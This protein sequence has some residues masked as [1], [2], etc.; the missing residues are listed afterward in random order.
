[1]DVNEL[2]RTQYPQ[3]TDVGVF[4]IHMVCEDNDL[5][6]ICMDSFAGAGD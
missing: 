1:M 4:S 5:K 2:F 6:N 3:A